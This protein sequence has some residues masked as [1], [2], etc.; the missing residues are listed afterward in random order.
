MNN[1]VGVH[2]VIVSS[3][4]MMELVKYNTA[5]GTRF[6]VRANQYEHYET[7]QA[8][9]D[10]NPVTEIGSC[11]MMDFDKDNVHSPFFMTEEQACDW[12]LK[13]FPHL[14]KVEL[15]DR[16]EKVWAWQLLSPMAINRHWMSYVVTGD[17]HPVA[18]KPDW[19]DSLRHANSDPVSGNF[20]SSHKG[21]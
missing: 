2:I 15:A 17:S 10:A 7:L 16:F 5:E 20:L 1:Q 14:T 6:G 3:V 4:N 19:V 8:Q 13:N 21:R 11:I 18:H 9:Q 12:G